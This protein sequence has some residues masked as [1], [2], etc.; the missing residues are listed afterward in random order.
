[1]LKDVE[2]TTFV[3]NLKINTV[4]RH[5]TISFIVKICIKKLL[6]FLYLLNRN[7]KI[8]RWE[9]ENDNKPTQME[10]A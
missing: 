6:F 8:F 2:I 3:N 7:N 10:L 5:G 4:L 9:K 1:M